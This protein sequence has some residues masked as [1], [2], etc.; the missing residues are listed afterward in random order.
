MDASQAA[1]NGSA[2]GPTGWRALA[3]DLTAMLRFHSRLPFPVLAFELDSHAA[4][5]FRRAPRM[6]AVAGAIIGLPGAAALLLAAVL[7]LPPLMAAGFGVAVAAMIT[8]AM[9]E[10]GLADSFDGLAGGRTPERRLAI[11]KDSRI[12]SFGAS[13]L[14]LGLLMR[15]SGLAALLAALGAAGGALAML[16]AA[17]LSRAVML[18]PLALLPPAR[19]DGASAAVGRPAA[20]T[21]ALALGTGLAIAAG[22]CAWAGAGVAAPV[23]GFVVAALLAAA[24]ILWSA[25]A[26]GGQTGDIAGACQQLAEIGFY[27]GLLI[28]MNWGKG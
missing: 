27:M 18:L 21:T 9:H 12:G 20:A 25:R 14:A 2:A 15:C 4:P 28:A 13:A 8:G 1:R 16:A 3:C 11:M 7:G 19:P 17:S 23:A 26:I 5:D 24:M 22:L 6:I 10:D